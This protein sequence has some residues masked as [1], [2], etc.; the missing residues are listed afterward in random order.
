MCMPVCYQINLRFLD[1]VNHF[2]LV[3]CKTLDIDVDKES[4]CQLL[5]KHQSGGRDQI[6][7]KLQQLLV[8]LEIL[9]LNL[10]SRKDN[11][12]KSDT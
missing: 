1:T 12:Q 8:Y 6:L 10:L 2:S 3:C 4:F 5:S 7:I 9:A 11:K